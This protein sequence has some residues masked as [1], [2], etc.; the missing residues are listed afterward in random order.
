MW[1]Y[2]FLSTEI[3]VKIFSVNIFIKSD[4]VCD[5]RKNLD[6]NQKS[7]INLIKL[8]LFLFRRNFFFLFVAK[9]ASAEKV[10]SI[11]LL[12]LLNLKNGVNI[13]IFVV[14]LRNFLAMVNHL[15]LFVEDK[16]ATY[17]SIE[18]SVNIMIETSIFISRAT[19]YFWNIM[20]F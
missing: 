10:W 4:V 16:I 17:R 2:Y 18:S 6:S 7:M 5:L 8:Y 20:F 9:I 3:F 11:P 13:L 15:L 1:T 19:S 14:E 12:S